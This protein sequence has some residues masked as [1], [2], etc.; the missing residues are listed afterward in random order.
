MKADPVFLVQEQL[1]AY[2]ARDLQRFL[3]VYS[4]SIV[5]YRMPNAEPALSGKAAFSDFYAKNRF[6]NPALNAELVSRMAFGNKVIDHERIM[7]LGDKPLEAAAV[8]EI[9]DGLI[10]VVWFYYGA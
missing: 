2:N 3:A 7:G 6:N 5:V 8:Y 4:E 1:E 10:Q 9:R